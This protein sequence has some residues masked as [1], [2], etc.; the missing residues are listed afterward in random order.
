M[1]GSSALAKILERRQFGEVG[2]KS[3][4]LSTL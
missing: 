1:A 4:H 3:P 2:S